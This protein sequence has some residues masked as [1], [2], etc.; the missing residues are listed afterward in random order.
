VSL[1]CE[2]V[3]LL[4]ELLGVAAVPCAPVG[5]ATLL[6]GEAGLLAAGLLGGRNVPLLLSR[7]LAELLGLRLLT[8][9]LGLWLLTQLLLRRLLTLL[10]CLRL[11]GLDLL[12]LWLLVLLGLRLLALVLDVLRSCRQELAGLG[13]AGSLLGYLAHPLSELL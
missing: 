9:L 13:V 3:R 5:A 6:A 7:L 10:L 11:L 12:C 4:S 1:F 8:H 2:V